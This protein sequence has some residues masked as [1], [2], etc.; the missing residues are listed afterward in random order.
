MCGDVLGEPIV[1]LAERL[2]AAVERGHALGESLGAEAACLERLLVAVECSLGLGD[3]LR[4]RGAPLGDG[5]AVLVALGGGVLDRLANEGAV[6]VDAGE[7]GEYG[8]FELVAVDPPPVAAA[9]A[10]LLAPRAGE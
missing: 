4:A 1:L 2:Q 10:E 6:A 3:F 5:S 9:A 8:G 7:L